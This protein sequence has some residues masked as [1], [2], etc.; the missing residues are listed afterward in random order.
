VSIND[1]ISKRCDSV[2]LVDLGDTCLPDV[3]AT[4]S[5]S[6]DDQIGVHGLAKPR[7]RLT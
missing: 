1:M 2:V 4:S 5:S 6:V 3:V 7:V